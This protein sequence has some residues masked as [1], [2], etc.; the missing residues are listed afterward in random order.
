MSDFKNKIYK[1]SKVIA[2]V[3]SDKMLLNYVKIFISGMAIFCCGGIMFGIYQFSH[4]TFYVILFGIIMLILK[5]VCEVYIEQY[6]KEK[7]EKETI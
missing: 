5:V 4:T 2:F 1:V 7:K 6:E 3:T